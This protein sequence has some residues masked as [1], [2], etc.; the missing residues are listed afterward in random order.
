MGYVRYGSAAALSAMN[1]VCADL[2]LLHNRF[3]P[4]AALQ[5]KERVG[6]T[7]RRYYDTPPPWRAC[8]RVDADTEAPLTRQRDR[9]APFA[10]FALGA[11]ID[12]Q[13]AHPYTLANHRQGRAPVTSGGDGAARAT[14]KPAAPPL[15]LTISPP[16]VT[17][18]TA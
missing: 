8:A 10:P 16:S 3:L 2:Q 15:S 7:H 5:R 18:L 6:A 9:F 11:R 1:A 14:R 4:S 12:R 17:P 13:L